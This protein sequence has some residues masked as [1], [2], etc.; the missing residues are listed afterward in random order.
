MAWQTQKFTP[1]FNDMVFHEGQIY[2]LDSGRVFCAD[3]GTG[4]VLWKTKDNFGGG[5]VLLTCDGLLVQAERGYLGLLPVSK[6]QRPKRPNR[7]AGTK[8]RRGTIRAGTGAI[9]RPQRA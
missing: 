2:G 1:E 7:G 8:H 4:K 9:V 6:D 5:Q 3:S